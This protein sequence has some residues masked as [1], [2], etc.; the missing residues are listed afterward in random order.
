MVQDVQLEVIVISPDLGDVT[1]VTEIRVTVTQPVTQ[2][3]CRVA[4]EIN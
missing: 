3:R 2:C 1:E 4:V